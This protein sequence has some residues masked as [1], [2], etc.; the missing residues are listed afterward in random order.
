MALSKINLVIIILILF[1]SGC[2]EKDELTLPVGISL[3]IAISID[4]SLNTEYLDFTNCQIGIQSVRF[5]GQREAGGDVFFESDF[6]QNFQTISFLQPIVISDFDIPQGVYNYMK[7][8]I[9][10]KCLDT[11]GL[12]DP[13][14][15]SHPCIGIV[16]SGEY[17][18]LDGSVIPF[19]LAIDEPEK[20]TVIA[21]DPD[22]NPTI[23][24]SVNK[25]YEA[26]VL[27]APEKAF[28]SISRE[29]FEEAEISVVNY[30]PKIVISSTENEDLYMILLYRIF[31][32]AKVVIK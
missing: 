11:D 27:F 10:M 17:E 7:W 19:I 13:R 14:D 3:K 25:R 9:S 21:C 32:F 18:T 26:T 22:D 8:D 23:V 4:N 24:L 30:N 31:Q 28:S 20:F 16:F 12:I 2:T 15:E 5:E 1:I 29:S 6:K